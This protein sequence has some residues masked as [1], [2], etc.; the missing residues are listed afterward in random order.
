MLSIK[1]YL[2][3]YRKNHIWTWRRCHY[4]ST[5]QSN[6]LSI[7]RLSKVQLNWLPKV[8]AVQWRGIAPKTNYGRYKLISRQYH[9]TLIKC[10]QR[11]KLRQGCPINIFTHTHSYYILYLYTCMLLIPSYLISNL[12]FNVGIISLKKIIQIFF[13]YII[14]LIFFLRIFIIC[15]G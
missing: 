6:R 15:K 3:N 12:F 8:G 13:I 4:L 9:I 14:T 10:L 5:W 11:L 1:E 2:I 7:M